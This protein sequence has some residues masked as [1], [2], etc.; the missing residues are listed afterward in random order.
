M[1][2]ICLLKGFPQFGFVS[3]IWWRHGAR[4]RKIQPSHF[5]GLPVSGIR[6]QLEA[7]LVHQRHGRIAPG[8][9]VKVSPEQPEVRR[10]LAEYRIASG[11]K[12]SISR[13]EAINAGVANLHVLQPQDAVMYW[14]KHGSIRQARYIVGGS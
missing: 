13:F 14:L 7:G 5:A 1:I 9:G 10:L 2:G 4:S 12:V 3:L 8:V 11:S 6:I